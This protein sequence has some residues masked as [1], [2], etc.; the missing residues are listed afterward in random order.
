MDRFNADPKLFCFI[1]STR[2]GGLGINLTGA[3]TVIFY[4]TDWNPAM[5]AQA[6]D[7]AHRIGQTRDVH[8]YRLVSTSTVEENILLKAKQKR[9]LDFLVMTEGKFSETSLFSSRSIQNVLSESSGRPGALEDK[10]SS[11]VDASVHGHSNVEMETAMLAAEDEDDVAAMK[12]VQAE[13]DQEL[14]EFSERVP[15]EAKDEALPQDLVP[16]SQPPQPQPLEAPLSASAEEQNDEREIESE[17][18]SWQEKIGKDFKALELA[19]KPIERY[20][21]RFRTDVDP[22][23]SMYFLTEQAKLEAI[24]ADEKSEDWDIDAIEKA[25]Q[26]E[27]ARALAEGELLATRITSI[28]IKNLQNWY[29]TEHARRSMERRRRKITGESWS[30]QY[31]DGIPFWYNQDTGEATFQTPKVL[32]MLEELQLAREKGFGFLPLAAIVHVFS[33]LSPFPDRQNSGLACSRWREAHRHERFVRRVLPVETGAKDSSN[34]IGGSLKL[35]MNTYASIEEAIQDSLPG[36]TITLS[37]GHYW[38]DN[39]FIPHP[40]KVCSDVDNEQDDV[41]KPTIELM[42]SIHIRPGAVLLLG[43]LTIRRPKLLPRATSLIRCHQAHLKV[44]LIHT[45]PLTL[46]LIILYI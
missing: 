1:L 38:E 22:F 45:H 6:Q 32:R 42:G 35:S 19:L 33:F 25:K 4:D 9:H 43:G 21:L 37:H 8:I 12:N 41:A 30:I 23:Y 15:E 34:R 27:E 24:T 46:P 29:A 18:A 39:L 17:F 14:D 13:V 16:S 20:A 40:L 11:M 28:D 3:D 10:I 2:S 31:D 44:P 7:R 5:D 26:D 36:D